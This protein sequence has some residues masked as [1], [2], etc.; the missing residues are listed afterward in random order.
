MGAAV[1]GHGVV[2]LIFALLALLQLFWL[3]AV[4]VSHIN[5]DSKGPLR[6]I[7]SKILLKVG[8]I[9]QD[10]VLLSVKNF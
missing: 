9:A 6:L 7:W 1:T 10:L 5:F 4:E 2:R 8:P 3:L